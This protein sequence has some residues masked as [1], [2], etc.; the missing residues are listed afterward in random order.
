MDAIHAAASPE[1][2]VSTEERP[3]VRRIDVQTTMGRMSVLDYGGAGVDSVM[4]HSPGFCADSLALVA[5]SVRGTC[6]VYSVELPGHGQSPVGGMSGAEFWP[7]IP[8][9]VTG[10]G[11]DRP[12][13][14]GFDLAG[15]FVTAAAATNPG[16][17]SSVIDVGGWCLRTREESAEFLEMVTDE[18]V[19]AGLAERMQL[20]ASAPDPEGV[21]AIL[22][23]L[24][25]NAIHDFLIADEE[26]R[27]VHKIACTVQVM[28]D[29]TH[30][31][32]PTVDTM[33]LLH[34]V[35][36]DDP[37]YPE[38]GLVEHIDVPH[39]F[40]LTTEGVDPVLIDR[41]RALARRRTNVH[42]ALVPAGNNPQMSEPEAVGRAIARAV[43]RPV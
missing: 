10:L 40:V 42:T 19:L 32:L 9:I 43:L 21:Q 17:V 18:G 24:A 23:V 26:S 27:F 2:A 33:R 30:V 29:G 14:V 36:V 6:R 28:D 38:S 11:L 4:F 3:G 39:T 8:E 20:G 1:V 15:F 25:R 22:R 13:L 41:A 37:V 16:T 31:R 35:P 12:V 7:A 34:E 5:E